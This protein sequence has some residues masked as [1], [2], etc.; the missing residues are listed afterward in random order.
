MEW[1][2]IKDSC[3]LAWEAFLVWLNGSEA[4]A[5]GFGGPRI[6]ESGRLIV[7]Y[8]CPSPNACTPIPFRARDLYDFFDARGI[9][10]EV[11]PTYKANNV[12]HSTR[13][14][15]FCD[16]YKLGLSGDPHSQFIY[17]DR[18]EAESAA[19]TKAFEIREQQLKEQQ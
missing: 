12:V 7:D 16:L 5:V 11:H 3:P 15:I 17:K 6:E 1:Q 8:I 18:T 10:V 9:W 4:H 2:Q 13:Y 19:F 14:H